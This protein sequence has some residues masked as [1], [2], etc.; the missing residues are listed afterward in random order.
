MIQTLAF[1]PAVPIGANHVAQAADLVLKQLFL[2]HG[3]LHDWQQGFVW[4]ALY[5]FAHPAMQRTGLAHHHIE[6]AADHR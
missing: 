6:E 3:E 5:I 2:F 4:P 1:G